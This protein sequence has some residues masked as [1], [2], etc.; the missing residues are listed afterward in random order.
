MTGLMATMNA[1]EFMAGSCR[2]L[3]TAAVL[4][5]LA[6][7]V[8]Y[9]QTPESLPPAQATLPQTA[10]EP[11]IPSLEPPQPVSHET[12]ELLPAPALVSP[13][14]EDPA[15]PANAEWA[16]HSPML[17]Q[18]VLPKTDLQGAETP[19]P[20]LEA[21]PASSVQSPEL[22][23]PPAPVSPKVEGPAV[24]AP[25]GLAACTQK[26]ESLPAPQA[27]VVGPPGP[28]PLPAPNYWQPHQWLIPWPNCH[29]PDPLLE[30]R[31]LPPPG[32]FVNVELDI[33]DSHVSNDLVNM[34]PVTATR[35]DTVRVQGADLNWTAAPLFSAGYRL[36][37][38]LGEFL[39]SYRYLATEGVGLEPSSQ[40]PAMEKSRLDV[41]YWDFDY[42]NREFSLG[43]HWDMCWTIGARLANVFFDA[44]AQTVPLADSLGATGLEQGVSSNF[45][46]AGPHAKLELERKLDRWGLA[47]SG[48]VEGASLW[49]PVGQNF[50]ET[51][52]FAGAPP[53]HVANH[54][55]INQGVGVIGVH[56]GLRWTPPTTHFTY[57][58][59]G[60][61]IEYWGQVGRD[62]NTG[63]RG[64]FYDQ[65]FFLRG[66]I[67]F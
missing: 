10:A 48:Q 4:A 61:E 38:G 56:T 34:L 58:F 49:G 5:L 57:F 44:R 23:P 66:E 19:T 32:W 12:P 41:N 22:L 33:V 27:V 24:P 14:A 6:G 35:T 39:F 42:A 25:A 62:D 11:T 31:G 36:P 18:S 65:G 59:L 3:L 50:E 63:S 54:D 20:S 53:L 30:D 16:A 21:A 43:P 29:E 2:N 55:S 26:P 37:H 64:N 67:T 28:A 8:V 7:P 13:Q 51:L 17:P 46:G 47:L 45:L 40:G 9:S 52:S 60:Y 15:T 1:G